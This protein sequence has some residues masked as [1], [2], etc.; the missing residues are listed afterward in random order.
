MSAHVDRVGSPDLSLVVPYHNVG[1]VLVEH[2]DALCGTLTSSGVTFEVIAVDDGSTDDTPLLVE[3]VTTPAV[4][5]V[6][7]APHRGKGEALRRGLA[8]ARGRYVGFIDGDGDLPAAN[9]RPF[10]ELMRLYEPDAV[11]G[12]K[13]HQLSE[14]DYPPLRRVYS[15]GFQQLV[16]VLFRVSVRDT[17]TGIKLFRREVLAAALPLTR[18]EGF[19]FDVELLALAH[20]LG[21]R[22]FLE[23]PVQL[24]HG[25]TSTISA[26]TAVRMLLDA[27]RVACRVRACPLSGASRTPTAGTP[28]AA[29]AEAV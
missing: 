10:V 25:F 4:R 18:E 17:Q 11:V 9:M 16:R 24:T 29:A 8:A 27:L 3:A 26:R 6:R 13:R 23:A 14:V 22:Q 2:I 7:S 28:A 20:R 21:Y 19:V 12:S 5:S 15:W 1:S